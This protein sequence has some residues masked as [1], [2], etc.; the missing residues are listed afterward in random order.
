[1]AVVPG[2]QYVLF[3]ARFSL[4][5][6]E[7]INQ[8]RQSD[9]R[10]FD[11][12]KGV[13]QRTA[14]VDVDSLLASSSSAPGSRLGRRRRRKR[15]MSKKDSRLEQFIKAARFVRGHGA[16]AL[17]P[18]AKIKLHGLLMQAKRGD[19]PETAEVTANTSKLVEL[20]LDSW[21][22]VKG[23]TQEEAMNEYIELLTSLAPNW[24][25]AHFVLGRESAEERRKPRPMMWVLKVVFQKSEMTRIK[26]LVEG[27]KSMKRMAALASATHA[28]THCLLIT[29]IE[30]LQS[31]NEANARLWTEEASAPSKG[32]PSVTSKHAKDL[33]ATATSAFT[34]YIAKFPKDLTLE[35]CILNKA[36]RSTL[37]EQRA[38]YA[39]RLLQ[40]SQDEDWKPYGKA[41]GVS[42]STAHMALDEQLDV[43]ERNV[44]WSP[45]PQLRSEYETDFEVDEIFAFWLG[46][47]AG[48]FRGAVETASENAPQKLQTMESGYH[49]LMSKIAEDRL[50]ATCITYREL[51]FPWPLS[52]RYMLLLQDYQFMDSKTDKPW[53][54]TY[55][56]D[57]T[58]VSYLPFVF[59]RKLRRDLLSIHP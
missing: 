18:S 58:V 32:G 50:S 17:H 3:K 2:E 12:L 10:A 37:A 44:E 42:V 57:I 30:I 26:S 54:V 49:Y 35:D 43:Y 34:R 45:L 5:A 48:V 56:E 23:K 11:G 55:N 24:K 13:L 27:G 19:C 16:A 52:P 22:S 29:R 38:H 8:W 47:F 59:L 1:M 6:P 46:Q 53:L 36:E 4:I 15:K 20:Q 51:P 21:R 41:K 28:Q 33:A 25:V 14:S 7:R 39:E 9:N 31:S 40:M